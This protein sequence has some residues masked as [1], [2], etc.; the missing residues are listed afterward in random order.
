MNLFISA[1]TIIL[2]EVDESKVTPGAIG[3]IVMGLLC[4]ATF[5]LLRNF[6]K[7]LRRLRKDQ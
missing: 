7:R 2:A 4:V 5:L 3:S 1:N 6:Y